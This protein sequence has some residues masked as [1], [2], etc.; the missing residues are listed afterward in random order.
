MKL[1]ALVLGLVVGAVGGVAYADGVTLAD[2][3][4]HLVGTLL[5]PEVQSCVKKY[6]KVLR[7]KPV[8]TQNIGMDA[9][10]YTVIY[11]I[12]GKSLSTAGKDGLLVVTERSYDN[13]VSYSCSFSELGN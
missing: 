2:P 1:K 11:T 12:T 10:G 3:T 6:A 7:D 9:Q 8:V 13:K 4:G 5:N